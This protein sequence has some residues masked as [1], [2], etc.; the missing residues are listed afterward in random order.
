LKDIDV[1]NCVGGVCRYE[2]EFEDVELK[3]LTRLYYKL[4]TLRINFYYNVLLER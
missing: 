1:K 2:P 4:I 3:V